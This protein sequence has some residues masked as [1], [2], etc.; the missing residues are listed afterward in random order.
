[1]AESSALMMTEDAGT[2]QSPKLIATQEGTPTGLLCCEGAADSAL[3]SLST[4]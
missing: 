4:T 3:R 2:L 1:M